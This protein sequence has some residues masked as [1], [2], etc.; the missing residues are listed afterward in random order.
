MRTYILISLP[1]RNAKK[2]K[3]PPDA[4]EIRLLGIIFALPILSGTTTP[5]TRSRMP[6]IIH[7]V[8]RLEVLGVVLF[9]SSAAR[10]YAF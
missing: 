1:F 3:Q 4:Q 10:K 8:I 2:I 6:D 7:Y 5:D 9:L